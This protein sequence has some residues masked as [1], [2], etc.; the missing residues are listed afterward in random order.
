ML[1]L[2]MQEGLHTIRRGR[3]L[4]IAP[5]VRKYCL[6]K[7]IEIGA[8]RSPLGDPARTTFLDK[9]EGDWDS[10]AGAD[11]KA[12]AGAIPVADEAFNYVIAS[13]VLEHVQNTIRTLNEWIRVLKPGGVIFLVLPHA[14]R[15]IDRFR[16]VTTLEH[17]IVDFANLTD[18]PDRSHFE[19]MKA[20]WLKLPESELGADQYVRQWGAE[21]WD[22]DF[23][24]AHSVL[25]YHVW[26]QDEIVAL[27]QY[28]G[29]K[30]AYVCDEAPERP[31]S[32]VVVAR[33][34]PAPR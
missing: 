27:L 30:I 1:P 21:L 25:H 11:L 34:S 29:L 24:I 32:F 15:T 33:L 8:G 31:D 17:H 3:Q 16:D 4:V 13:H 26:T 2:H 18:E 5:A 20:G 14:E 6:G 23:R 22:W 28:L 19:E 10:T 9:N 12:D 7:G